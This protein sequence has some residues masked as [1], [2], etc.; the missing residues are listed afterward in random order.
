MMFTLLLALAASPALAAKAEGPLAPAV[1]VWL[2]SAV[3]ANEAQGKA[4]R[5]TGG[6]AD[7]G[8]ADL[9]LTPGDWTE[10]DR[11]KTLA[12]DAAY[13]TGRKRWDEFDVEQGIAQQ[14]QIAADSV[15]VLRNEADRESLRKALAL[16]GTAA[17]KAF[18]EAKFGT[19]A[20]ATSFRTMVSARAVPKALVDALA[21]DPDHVWTRDEVGDGLGFAILSQLGEDLRAQPRAT[22]AV[23]ERPPGAV[24]VVD[25]RPI[26]P[27]I[28]QLELWPG[29]HYVHALV[30]N[31]IAGRVTL[32][33]EAGQ[34][35]AYPL[36]VGAADLAAARTQLLAGDVAFTGPVATGI[37]ALSTVR[38]QRARVYVAALDDKGRPQVVPYSGGAELMRPSPISVLLAGDLGIGV[39]R[40]QAYKD[41]A[42]N[43]VSALAPAG[44]LGVEFG[45]YNFAVLAGATLYLTP[46]ERM[47][48]ANADNTANN[49]TPA[50]FRPYGGIGVYIP[51]PTN[52][53]PLILVGANYGAMLPGSSGFGGLVS[54][55]VPMK[56]DGTWVRFLMDVYAGSQ[57]AGYPGAGSTTYGLTLRVGFGQKL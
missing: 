6:G 12:V 37:E 19:D 44:N 16:S 15:S 10:D 18:P 1:V 54:V 3:P 52:G 42:E 5:L 34:N 23:G 31:T 13:E 53:V 24:L 28:T 8:W 11:L 35:A 25:G 33:L 48:F 20:A 46:N 41:Q 29:R 47:A 21:L 4:H 30:G 32:N 43:Y 39:V 22:L 49:D 57:A 56:G 51:R 45:V 2:E 50:Y 36:A 40:S 9:A 26:D 27:A 55:G 14:I 17:A 38:G 7:L